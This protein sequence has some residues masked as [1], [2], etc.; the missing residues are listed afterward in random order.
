MKN[1]RFLFVGILFGI[2]MTKS[3]AIS[4]FRI[5]EMFRFQSIHMYGIIGTAVIIGAIVTY[6]IK[7]TNMK[8][9]EGKEVVIEAKENTYIGRIL[10]GTVFGFGWAMTGACPG[11]LYTLLGHGIWIILVVILSALLGTFV[12]GLLKSKLPH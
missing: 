9:I 6:L 5:Q 2:V 10:G 8:S 12:Y 1:I 7:R 11:P 4:W 3:E